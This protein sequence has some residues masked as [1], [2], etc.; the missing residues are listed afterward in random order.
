[1]PRIYLKDCAAGDVIEDEAL[2][3]IQV[4]SDFQGRPLG[5]FLS[6]YTHYTE[7]YMVPN[8]GGENYADVKKRVTDFLYRCEE[9]YQGKNILI[10]THGSPVLNMIL[11]ARGVG[12]ETIADDV[13][14]V[15]YPHHAQLIKLDF[16]TS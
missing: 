2:K 10:V 7:R 3:E 12:H 15:N 5:D 8:E 14:E 4:G 9:T 13:E 11:G 6:R 1:M 16:I